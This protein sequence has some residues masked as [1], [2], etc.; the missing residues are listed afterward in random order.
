MGGHMCGACSSARLER[1][2]DKDEAD[3]SSPSRPTR[4]LTLLVDPLGQLRRCP[5]YLSGGPS[6]PEPHDR[7][8][9]LGWGACRTPT[10]GVGVAGCRERAP[11]TPA[12]GVAVWVGVPAGPR[13]RGWGCGLQWE[14]PRTPAIGVWGWG[15]RVAGG[16]PPEPHARLTLLVD[17]WVNCAVAR[18]VYP[19]GPSP[20]DPHDWGWGCELRGDDPRTCTTWRGGLDRCTSRDLHGSNMRV[21]RR[22]PYA[23]PGLLINFWPFVSVAC[24]IVV[25]GIWACGRCGWSR[26]ASTRDWFPPVR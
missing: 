22:M 14:G 3:G 5:G 4:R 24:P 11:R 23:V 19:G 12:I 7:G 17:S 21:R 25:H 8:C 18:G 20:P 13:D 15:L 16:R 2:P 10:V 6:P 1:I 26:T 9:C